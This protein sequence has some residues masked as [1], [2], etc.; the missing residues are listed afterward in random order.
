A[1]NNAVLSLV[2]DFDPAHAR[3]L[4]QRYFGDIPAGA[5]VPPIP[6]RIAIPLDMAGEVRETVEQDISLARVYQAYRIPA[7]GTDEYYA[8][9]V[10]SYI[11]GNGKAA[12]LYRTLVRE[13]Q[14]AQDVVAY[15]FPIVVGASMLVMWATAR[16]GASLDALDAALTEQVA[17]LAGVDDADVERAI[18][19]LEARHLTDLQTVDE[20]ADQLSMYTTIFDDPD[21]INTELARVSG[22]TTADVRAFATRY[23]RRDNRAVL[24]YVPL[25]G[26]SA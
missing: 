4:I 13:Q 5:P 6:G 21:R 16:P 10:A 7:Y 1:P 14:L 11:L 25:N 19:M 12:V 18:A 8:G 24:L 2:G 17:A 3:E 9:L 22:V 26:A 20:R 23:L 15:A